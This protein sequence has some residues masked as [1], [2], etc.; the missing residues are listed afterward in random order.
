MNSPIRID[1]ADSN[2]SDTKR[3]ALASGEVAPYSAR[4]VPASSPIGVPI[5]VPIPVWI[6]VPTIAFSKPPFDPGGFVMLVNTESP[7]P[8]APFQTSVNR[9]DASNSNPINVARAQSALTIRLAR[10]RRRPSLRET[11][12]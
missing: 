5:R 7:R 1:G 3:T 8:A 6:N 11:D 2:T 9:I 4:Y 12:G 10:Y